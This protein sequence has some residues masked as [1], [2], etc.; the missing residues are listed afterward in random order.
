LDVAAFSK[1]L[2]WEFAGKIARNTEKWTTDVLN[3]I[4]VGKRGRGRPRPRWEDEILKM[5]GEN[6]KTIAM[7]KKAWSNLG[8]TF[9]QQWIDNAGPSS[10]LNL[11]N[12]CY[13]S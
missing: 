11:L 2:K 6:W 4:P 5:A 9:I 3:W 7:D 12:V 10:H 8:E 13:S 1:K